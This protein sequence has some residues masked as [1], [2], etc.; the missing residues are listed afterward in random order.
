[1]ILGAICTSKNGGSSSKRSRLFTW[2]IICFQNQRIPALTENGF[3]G[4]ALF[5]IFNIQIGHSCFRRARLRQIDTFL[6][7][8]LKEV[9]GV[10]GV[11]VA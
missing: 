1:L 4:S 9:A 11:F 7:F 5:H 10:A 8:S 3:S 6:T 2:R